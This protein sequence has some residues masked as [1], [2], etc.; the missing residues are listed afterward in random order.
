MNTSTWN[1]SMSIEELFLFD[2]YDIENL[3]MSSGNST[4][5]LSHNDLLFAGGSAISI[6]AIGLILNQIVFWKFL[7]PK[8]LS[9]SF[10][11]LCLSKSFS[12]TITCLIGL[13][14]IGPTIAIN[15]LFLPPDVNKF[16]GQFNEY[17]VYTMGPLTQTLMTIDR[18]IMIFYPLKFSERKRCKIAVISIFCCWFIALSFVAATYN[19]DCWVAYNISILNYI[20][21]ND[22]CD[23][24][25]L[26]ILTIGCIILAVIT[27]SFQ[28]SNLTKILIMFSKSSSPELASKSQKWRTIRLFVQSVIQDLLHFLDLLNSKNFF[29]I[30]NILGHFFIFTFS[31]LF[32]HALDGLIMCFFHCNLRRKQRSSK[33]GP[34][35]VLI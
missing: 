15:N 16:L 31:L 25:N 2:Q 27:L 9:N 10:H 23:K 4:Q 3:T 35:V 29:G 33:N 22:A 17:G 21:K 8:Q 12:N 24:F 19:D 6:S 5:V 20:A 30:T 7:S 28:T 11:V 34:L 13:F 18:F 14:W 1:D 32:V 26:K